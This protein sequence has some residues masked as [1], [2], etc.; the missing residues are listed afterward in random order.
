[1]SRTAAWNPWR[2]LRARPHITHAIDPIADEA[3]GAVHARIG[4]RSAIVL[5]PDLDRIDR[6]AALAHE[7]I[8][9]E[10]G[11]AAPWAT[12]ATMQSE[13]RI[14]RRETARRLVP[15]DHLLA[16]VEARVSVEP[17]T[18]ALVADEYEV[19]HTVAAEALRQL[20][21]R[22]LEAEMRRSAP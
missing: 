16:F 19:P 9:D 14:V 8:H 18:V 7:L 4:D 13:E 11:I 10:R 2:A 22:L 5:S 20:Q 1:M 15:L 12:D 17:V 3:G 21:V 6:N